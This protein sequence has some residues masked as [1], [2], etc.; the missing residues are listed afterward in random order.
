MKPELLREFFKQFGGTEK[1]IAMLKSKEAWM[2]ALKFVRLVRS[3]H[4][5][6]ERKTAELD[7]GESLE[8]QVLLLK[9]LET[10]A[11][12]EVEAYTTKAIG[13]QPRPEVSSE[14]V[15]VDDDDA[16][17]ATAFESEY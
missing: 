16:S 8:Y 6:K 12:E 3:T 1:C 15:P 10:G 4:S 14:P 5:Q 11:Y 13:L 2:V 7:L 17:L 9:A